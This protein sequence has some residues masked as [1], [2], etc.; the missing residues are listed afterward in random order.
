MQQTNLSLTPALKRGI[1]RY[2]GARFCSVYVKSASILTLTL[3]LEWVKIAEKVI[4][5]GRIK[6]GSTPMPSRL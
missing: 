2:G 3:T 5:L 6:S 1:W 4:A